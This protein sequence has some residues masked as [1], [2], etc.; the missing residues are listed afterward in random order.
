MVRTVKLYRLWHRLE[1]HPSPLLAKEREQFFV[2]C[3]ILTPLTPAIPAPNR[4]PSPCQGEGRGEVLA[5]AK[6]NHLSELS[7]LL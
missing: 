5:Y 3:K 1:P 2:D 4:P 7:G 6:I